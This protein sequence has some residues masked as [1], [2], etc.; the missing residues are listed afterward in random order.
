M[1]KGL[2]EKIKVQLY[3][4]LRFE[5]HMNYTFEQSKSVTDVR[6]EIMKEIR[7]RVDLFDFAIELSD[8]ALFLVFFLLIFKAWSYRHKYLTK[9]RFDNAYITF[10]VRDIDVR[11]W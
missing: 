3:V 8:V 1:V 4:D 2:V 6:K 11:S 5:H 9:D 7:E 10:T